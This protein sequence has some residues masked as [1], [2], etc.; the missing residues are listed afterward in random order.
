MIY[1][2]NVESNIKLGFEFLTNLPDD[3]DIAESKS[4]KWVPFIMSL[5]TPQETI[6]ITEKQKAYMTV[7]E[8]EKI[9]NGIKDLLEN[10][11]RNEDRMFTHYSYE[12]FFE[13]SIEYLYM[14]EG[15]E[16]VLWFIIAEYSNSKMEGYNS[17]FRFMA[18]KIE[19]KRFIEEF[20]N[21]F[22]KICP[23]YLI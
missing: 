2:T 13:L 8:V 22:K 11:W 1:L 5:S 21:S 7:Y 9:Y 20:R 18:D 3:F 15:F 23:Q 14:D 12:S 4:E 16:V 10:T 19:I 17:G 6:S